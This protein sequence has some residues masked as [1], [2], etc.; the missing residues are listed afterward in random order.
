MPGFVAYV[1]EEIV[2]RSVAVQVDVI[3]ESVRVDMVDQVVDRAVAA[4]ENDFV[5]VFEV[6][7]VF[8]VIE[9]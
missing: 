2:A 6:R 1:V 3:F 7:E 5:I 4:D 8:R 9:L